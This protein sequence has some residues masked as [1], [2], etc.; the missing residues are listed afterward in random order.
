MAASDEEFKEKTA[1]MM[2]F[3]MSKLAKLSEFPTHPSG[4]QYP[5]S[6][7]LMYEGTVSRLAYMFGKTTCLVMEDKSML[8][9]YKDFITEMFRMHPTSARITRMEM[10][11]EKNILN[12]FESFA[13]WF[14]YFTCFFFSFHNVNWFIYWCINLNQYKNYIWIALRLEG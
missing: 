5:M 14:L 12:I 3:S 13:V 6:P 1:S 2:V 8:M 9:K 10:A 7:I 4:V 11:I